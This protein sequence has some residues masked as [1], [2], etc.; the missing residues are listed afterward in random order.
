MLRLFVLHL[1]IKDSL[2]VAPNVKLC[3]VIDKV[4][5]RTLE[6]IARNKPIDMGC[7]N[8][9]LTLVILHWLMF[10]L[11]ITTYSEI[12]QA[13]STAVSISSLRIPYI[14]EH[15]SQSIEVKKNWSSGGFSLLINYL[16]YLKH[17]IAGQCCHKMYSA[18]CHS[19]PKTLYFGDERYRLM[20]R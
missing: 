12:W 9:L 7:L 5:S 17:L 14:G 6:W 20:P 19:M 13:S 1:L 16:H 18:N 8:R 2:V 10:Q 4:T 11:T 15:N 3:K